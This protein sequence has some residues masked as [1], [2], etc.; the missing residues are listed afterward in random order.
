M[1]LEGLGRN[2]S[3]A[4]YYPDAKTILLERNYRSREPVILASNRVI[5]LNKRQMSKRVIA[6]R[7]GGEPVRML[8]AQDEFDQAERVVNT[9]T[10]LRTAFPELKW[11]DFAVLY[12]TN[13]E[14][15]PFEEVLYEKHVPY[16][17][18]DG[19]HFFEGHKAKPILAYMRL[20][21]RL[22]RDE[23]PDMDNLIVALKSPKG[24]LSR[25][26]IERVQVEGMGVLNSH[27]DYADYIDSLGQFLDLDSP[28]IFLNKL[29]EVYP[30]LVKTEPGEVWLDVLRRTCS[31]FP[32][33]QAFLQ[34]VEYVLQQAKEPKDDAVRFMS[35]HQSK[36]LEFGTVFIAVNV[37]PGTP[38]ART[39]FVH[40]R[41]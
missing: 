8:H 34:H 21:D 22:N 26:A 13:Q 19:T 20:L 1:D 5:A 3:F 4:R 30:D 36:G 15:V 40:N 17:L 2:S 37:K 38:C 9:I 10:S 32:T 14:S 25:A 41:I 11:S 39:T 12:R 18:T 35:I 27:P 29:G 16:E 7:K 6:N 33:L 31:R 24:N 23:I 28:M